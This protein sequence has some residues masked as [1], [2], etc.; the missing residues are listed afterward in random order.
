MNDSP[1]VV[2]PYSL[3][4]FSYSSEPSSIAST[5][6]WVQSVPI[7]LTRDWLD[8]TE[9]IAPD[10]PDVMAWVQERYEYSG[11]IQALTGGLMGVLVRRELARSEPFGHTLLPCPY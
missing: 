10:F 5:P 9:H 2:A 3:S 11:H 4:P 6:C 8:W 7:V 1:I